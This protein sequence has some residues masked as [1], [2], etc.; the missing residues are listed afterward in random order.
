MKTYGAV[1]IQIQKSK[2][3]VRL[4]RKFDPQKDTVYSVKQAYCNEQGG[5]PDRIN[6]I[7]NGRDLRNDNATLASVGIGVN[8]RVA[9]LT[10]TTKVIG[11]C[12]VNG[13]KVLLSN[14]KGANIED[15]SCNDQVLTYNMKLNR[16][17]SHRVKSILKYQVNVLVTLKLANGASITCTPCHPFYVASKQRWCCVDPSMAQYPGTEQLHVGKLCVGDALLC[18]NSDLVEIR[19]I[20][21]EPVD[22]HELITVRTM[23]VSGANHNFFANDVLV[24]NKGGKVGPNVEKTSN[25]KTG[26][27]SYHFFTV[28]PGFM[29]HGICKTDDCKAKDEPVT[30]HRGFDD[31]GFCPIDEQFEDEDNEHEPRCPGCKQIFEVKTYKLYQCDCVVKFKKKSKGQKAGGKLDKKIFKPRGDEVI[32]LGQGDD[33]VVDN[34]AEYQVLKFWV[35]KQGSL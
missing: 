6:L 12:F 33:G 4:A 22:P 32:N 27:N 8:R 2:G 17:E 23:E 20:E 14:L 30:Y 11:G 7:Y 15:V 10:L 25:T 24:H 16:T 1:T 31:S 18:H 28:S 29:Y 19:E 26:N 3:Y 34:K 13:T 35:Y 5:D 9:I 21:Q